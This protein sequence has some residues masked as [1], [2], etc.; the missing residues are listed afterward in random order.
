MSENSENETQATESQSPG[1]SVSES[2]EQPPPVEPS[3]V[4]YE[5]IVEIPWEKAE[6]VFRIREAF[7]EMQ[8]HVAGFLLDSERR[9]VAM[10]DRLAEMESSL[11]ESAGDLKQDPAINPEWVYELKLPQQPEE[12]AY[13]IRKQE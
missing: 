5:E 11:Y 9:K 8:Q 12:K 1:T 10:M 2:A 7:K 3:E 4:S 6:N 13:L